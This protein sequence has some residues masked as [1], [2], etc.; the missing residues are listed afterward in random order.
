MGSLS[1]TRVKGLTEAGRYGDGDGLYLVVSPNGSRSWVQRIVADG[2]RRDVGL[3]GFPTVSLA[4][5]RDLAGDNRQ[6]VQG[7]KMPMSA[8]DRRNAAAKARSPKASKPTFEDEARAFHAENSGARWTNPKNIKSWM[9]R[10]EKYIFPVI[11][12]KPIVTVSAADVLDIL[13]P[14]QTTKG[15]TATRVRVILNQVFGRAVARGTITTNPAD[16]RID[17]ALPPKP[18][19]KHMLALHHTQVADALGKVDASDA[20][21]GTKLAFWFM[22]LTATRGVE[23]RGALWSEMDLAASTWTIPADRMKM[24][25]AHVVP[26]SQQAMDVLRMANPLADGSEWVFPGKTLPARPL[27]D[28]TFGKMARDLGLGCNPHGF[29]SSFRDWTAE[30]SSASWAAVELSL[31]HSVGSSV[32]RAYFRSNLLE[33]RRDLMEA[34]G[35]YIKPLTL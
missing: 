12:D 29:R 2:S 10:A 9:Q 18:A 7:G 35:S 1:A 20:Y 11:G 14:L 24:G 3:G 25:R 30:C 16:S 17:P 28:N 33:Q 19:A 22:V 13:T 23:A 15:E 27:S 34:W 21:L 6:R 8:K 32:E 26:L 5:A 4:M 31:A